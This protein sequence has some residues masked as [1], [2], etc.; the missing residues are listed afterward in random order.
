MYCFG[1]HKERQLIRSLRQCQ[2]V[3]KSLCEQEYNTLHDECVLRIQEL[4]NLEGTS[5]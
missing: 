4:V 3:D 2:T 1:S 5:I